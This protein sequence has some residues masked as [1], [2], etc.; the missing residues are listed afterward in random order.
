MRYTTIATCTDPD[1]RCLDRAGVILY[2]G[3]DIEAA[4]TAQLQAPTGYE[5]I[6]TSTPD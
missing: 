2:D 1:C 3:P 5:V 4:E 6:T